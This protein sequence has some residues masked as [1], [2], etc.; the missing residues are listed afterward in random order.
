MTE[1]VTGFTAERMLAMEDA[2]VI[3]GAVVGDDLILTTKDG[4]EIDAGNVRGPQGDV[5]PPS[6]G[7]N[8]WPVG[9]VFISV[10]PTDP[11]TL[12]GGGTWARFAQGRV[13]VGLDESETEFDTV[14]E[15]G[16]EKTH[17]LTVP[18]MPTHSH[19]INHD[20]GD[21]ITSSDTHSHNID[22]RYDQNAVVTGS[23][24]RVM[25]VGGQPSGAGGSL[26]SGVTDTDAH[27]HVASTNPYNGS[28]ANYG[29]GGA[30]NNLQPYIVCYM[31]KRTA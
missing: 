3:S 2:T 27:T 8:A 30:H 25:K 28:S 4:T 10:V 11:A 18:E 7:I 21:S 24:Y 15:T 26:V 16:G 13:L 5:G 9:S 14:Q 19:S 17:T 23:G 6:L 12:L 1:S 22:V 29:G 31:W 20:H